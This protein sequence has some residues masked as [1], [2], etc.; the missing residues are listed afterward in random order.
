[1]E[2]LDSILLSTFINELMNEFWPALVTVTCITVPPIQNT[3]KNVLD[4]VYKNTVFKLSLLMHWF[5]FF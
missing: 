5:Y 3:V 4:V 1:M 2:K